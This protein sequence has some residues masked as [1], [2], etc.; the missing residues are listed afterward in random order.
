[1]SSDR[2]REWYGEQ[3]S[4]RALELNANLS[5]ALVQSC[6]KRTRRLFNKR[7]RS[8]TPVLSCKE[9]MRDFGT[10]AALEDEWSAGPA[11][12]VD[13]QDRRRERGRHRV[14]RHAW[15]LL[16]CANSRSI[17]AYGFKCKWARKQYLVS[18][19]LSI[20][21]SG[22]LTDHEI[23]Q[24]ERRHCAQQLDLNKHNGEQR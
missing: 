16:I 14:L 2:V 18:G 20:R 5:L 9:E 4:R 11:G 3:R 22:V 19:C 8:H 1:M 7:L 24:S 6:E 13:V 12:V 21:A 23:V 17:L 10:F 15:I